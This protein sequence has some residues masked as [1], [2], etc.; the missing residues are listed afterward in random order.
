MKLH[1]K[2]QFFKKNF[3]SLI[4]EVLHSTKWYKVTDVFSEYTYK[5]IELVGVHLFLSSGLSF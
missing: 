3:R 5:Q 1:A 4:S 2:L